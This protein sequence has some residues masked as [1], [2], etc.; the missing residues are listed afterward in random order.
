MKSRKERNNKN[1][2]A[3][4]FLEKMKENNKLFEEK[5]NSLNKKK[6][7]VIKSNKSKSKSKKKEIKKEKKEPIKLTIKK[8]VQINLEG[9]KKKI[10][11]KFIIINEYEMTIFNRKKNK[12]LKID[13]CISF[14]I[15]STITK[16][17]NVNINQ[18]NYTEEEQDIYFI[19]KIRQLQK[20]LKY[21][22]DLIM[23]LQDK[24]KEKDD[25]Y[26]RMTREELNE[27]YDRLKNSE[28]QKEE[29]LKQIQK[30]ETVNYNQKVIIENLQAQ[31]GKLKKESKSKKDDINELNIVIDK[32]KYDEDSYAQKIN[33]LENLNKN[34]VKNFEIL[35]EDLE[36]VKNEKKRLEK[37]IEEQRAIMDKDRS[38]INTL[39]KFICEDEKTLN[40]MYDDK[41]LDYN[42]NVYKKVRGGRNKS[43]EVRKYNTER[44]NRYFDNEDNRDYN[45]NK[46]YNDNN[47][48]YNDNED[49]ND[50]NY[51]KYYND[52]DYNDNGER[53]ADN[54][55]NGN[56]N[57]NEKNNEDR[58]IIT[59]YEY[60]TKGSSKNKL[61]LSQDLNQ[62]FIKK[63]K[64][65]KSLKKSKSRKKD[66]ERT[67]SSF[68]NRI[69]RAIDDENEDN[70]EVFYNTF[71][72]LNDSNT[73]TNKDNNNLYEKELG[74]F[75]CEQHLLGK[76]DEIKKLESE[77]DVLL[78]EKNDIENEILKMPEHPKTLQEI[79]N[80][81][82]MNDKLS[83]AESNLNKV[84]T[85]LRKI[86]EA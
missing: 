63:K 77:L 56:V 23:D 58:G 8:D 57:E 2:A 37:I 5:M 70:K 44:K 15:I 6:I 50:N 35:R 79:K 49:Y 43:Q 75:P 18:N 71:T 68:K 17:R 69:K 46:Y 10:I 33:R 76:Q 26:V 3:N 42:D 83:L 72:N 51:N 40:R 9:E 80:K 60:K 47:K 45:G 81:K 31:I 21:K 19:S 59:S 84:R 55:I 74:Y 62:D 54:G 12:R 65:L 64:K 24:I 82:I 41:L 32:L 1:T 78:K 66:N 22:S 73:S 13:N 16:N 7:K 11:P 86:K 53:M 36:K 25:R 14:R 38:H 30:L 29:K 61:D 34:S 85:K 52:N 39:R 4:E 27:L 48:D 28:L 67:V 20:D